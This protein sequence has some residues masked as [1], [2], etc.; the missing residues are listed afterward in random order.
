[1]IQNCT[2]EEAAALVAA[3]RAHEESS[4]GARAGP[5]PAGAAAPGPGSGRP[6]PPR[7]DGAGV[8]WTRQGRPMGRLV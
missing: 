3:I 6:A 1:M 7:R 5:A 8:L 2:T 4:F